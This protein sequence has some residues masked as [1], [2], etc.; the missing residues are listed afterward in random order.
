MT[1]TSAIIAAGGVILIADDSPD[2]RRML[3]VRVK[4]EGHQAILVE[5]GRQALDVLAS[6]PVDVIL[7]DIDMPELDGFGVLRTVKADPNL[8]HLPVLI[9][10]GG[11]DQEDLVRCIELGAVDFL[12]KPFNQALLRARINAC[13]VQKRQRDQERQ[14]ANAMNETV[15]GQALL[16]ETDEWQVAGSRRPATQGTAAASVVIRPG[17][18]ASLSSSCWARAP[19]ARF[20]SASTTCLTCPSRSSCCDRS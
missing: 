19:A 1:E 20:T 8:A 2:A 13:L 14:R 12:P 7:L 9:I 17:W 4:R 5:N 18:G 11:G 15:P 16:T 10:S 6:Q 3:E